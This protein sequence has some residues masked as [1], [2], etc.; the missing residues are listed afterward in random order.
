[1]AVSTES[2]LMQTA[3]KETVIP[4]IRQA[5]FQG[6]YPHFR[7]IS[8]G[9][10]DLISFVGCG[11]WGGGYG[12]G[13]S[14]IFPNVAGAKSNRFYP[15]DDTPPRKMNWAHG[16][17]RCSLPGILGGTFY[18]TDVYARCVNDHAGGFI[19]YFPCTP[20]M[21]EHGMDFSANG[22]VLVQKAD[23]GIYSRVAA[24]TVRQLQWLLQ[25]FDRIQTPADLQPYGQV[26]EIIPPTEA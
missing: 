7:R 26:I 19:S 5:G 18:Y 2:K 21:I 11:I 15:N 8:D 24:E 16:R 6:S 13:A 9:K 3:L 17:K 4:I 1:M 22:E 14:V 12:V 20:K 25:W 10:V 23:D